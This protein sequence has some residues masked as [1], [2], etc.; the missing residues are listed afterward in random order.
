MPQGEALKNGVANGGKSY[1]ELLA[2][3]NVITEA[4][5]NSSWYFVKFRI[6]KRG[7]VPLRRSGAD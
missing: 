3:S 4:Q 6:V 2:S 7:V 5:E 1:R